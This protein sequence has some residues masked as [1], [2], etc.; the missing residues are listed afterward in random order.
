MSAKA[1]K[2]KSR[3]L[4]RTEAPRGIARIVADCLNAAHVQR[5]GCEVS[6]T[7]NGVTVRVV[8]SRDDYRRMPGMPEKGPVVWEVKR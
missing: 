6:V 4:S 1:L 2:D 8:A 3:P 5:L 7:G